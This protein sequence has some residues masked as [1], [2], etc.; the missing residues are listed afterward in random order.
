MIF[1]ELR[2]QTGIPHTLAGLKVGDDKSIDRQDAPE[3]PPQAA[4]P[5]SSTAAPRAPSSCARWRDDSS[6]RSAAQ[7]PAIAPKNT[8]AQ[9]PHQKDRAQHATLLPARP[10][11]VRA[12]RRESGATRAQPARERDVFHQAMSGN[13]PAASN[14]TRRDEYRLIAGRCR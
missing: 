14:A 12:H 11:V 7:A 8:Q 10:D 6:S 3:I 5:S 4:T 13:P 1:D 9:A 2:E